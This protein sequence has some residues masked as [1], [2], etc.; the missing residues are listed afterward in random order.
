V[1]VE[2]IVG[3]LLAAGAGI[4]AYSSLIERNAF[5]V[6]EESIDV[7]P[8]GSAPIRIL[9]LSDLH[10][11][12]W[13]KRKVRWLQSLAALKPDLI[14]A[15]GDFLGHEDAVPAVRDALRGF[16]GIPGVFVHGSNDYFGPHLPNPLKYL[17]RPSTVDTSRDQLDTAGLEDV[18][19]ALGWQ[20]LNNAACELTVN[21]STVVFAGTDD[22]HLDRDSLHA[23]TQ[24][25]ASIVAYRADAPSAVL[26][27][28]HAPY[29][30]VLDGLTALGAGALFAGHTHGGQVCL[31]FVGALTTNSDL[32][33]AF[34]RGLSTWKHDSREAYLNV[35][36]GIGT[37]I[38]APVRFFCPPE[39][40]LVTLRA[41]HIEYA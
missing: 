3:G 9:H 25:A 28:T 29:Q 19:A 41:R 10:L 31:P 40:V 36:A 20:N 2:A 4:F 8:D 21:G 15:T 26:G 32:P 34:A 22:P 18:Y 38:Y 16:A 6:R 11:A 17:W 1:G 33:V 23:V 7:L 13:Q 30:R 24:A 14:I 35:S 37:S 39:A 12:P 5:A 27:V